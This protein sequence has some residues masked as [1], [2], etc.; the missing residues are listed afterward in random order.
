ILHAAFVHPARSC[1]Q[2]RKVEWD[3]IHTSMRQI[4][5]TAVLYEGSTLSDGTYRNALNQE[6]GY[7][8]H[9]RVYDKADAI[10]LRCR[11]GKIRRVVQA[12]RSTFFC[13][14]CQP[15]SGKPSATKPR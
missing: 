6:G 15:R 12:Q 3:R 13:P 7:Q 4:L 14:I 5:E 8:N 10:C 1:D 2:V 9:H 11:E